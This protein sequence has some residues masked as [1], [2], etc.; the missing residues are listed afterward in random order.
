[1]AEWSINIPFRSSADHLVDVAEAARELATDEERAVVRQ[2]VLDE[3]QHGSTTTAGELLSKISSES[4]DDRRT[5]LDRAREAAGLERTVEIERRQR[6]ESMKRNA[7]LQAGQ[8]SQLQV[9]HASDCSAYPVD[10][11][12]GATKPVDVRKWWCHEHVDQAA[13]G[14][15]QPRAPRLKFS[16]SGAI[17][18]VDPAEEERVRIQAES[19]RALHESRLADAEVEGADM[20]R[21]EEAGR[22]QL[23]RETPPGM[24]T[25]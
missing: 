17:V 18:E 24:W 23:R 15:M 4:P 12:T 2:L 10:P 19:R 1:V 14:D 25:P 16:P 20:R 9:C 7:A 3:I 5:R 13:P 6:F 8:E 22:E 21:H 11:A